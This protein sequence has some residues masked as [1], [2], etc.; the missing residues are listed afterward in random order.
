M[1]GI[2]INI[3]YD[4]TLLG[5]GGDVVEE[6]KGEFLVGEMKNFRVAGNGCCFYGFFLEVQWKG[7]NR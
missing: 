4:F 3:D 2:T 5:G 7:E 6:E 1:N